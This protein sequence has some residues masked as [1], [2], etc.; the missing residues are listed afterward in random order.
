MI[1]IY[2]YHSVSYSPEIDPPTLTGQSE[3]GGLCELIYNLF[4]Y[5]KKNTWHEGEWSGAR[6]GK[7]L[8]LAFAEIHV[9][10]WK[11]MSNFHRNVQLYF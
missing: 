4:I 11:S 5:I 3:E 7:S 2:L 1:C 9:R 10:R 8:A 6:R